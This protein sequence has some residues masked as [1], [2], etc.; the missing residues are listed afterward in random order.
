M[1]QFI[2]GTGEMAKHLKHIWTP[3]SLYIQR[4]FSNIIIEIFFKNVII[5][6]E[7]GFEIENFK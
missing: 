2:K 5:F 3:V 1:V 4:N 6:Q 7:M